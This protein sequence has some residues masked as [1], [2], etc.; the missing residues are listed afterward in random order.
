MNLTMNPNENTY[1][2]EC[3]INLDIH[4]IIDDIWIDII[5]FLNGFDFISINQTCKYF[6]KLT[7]ESPIENSKYHNRIK[8]H[9]AIII[10][11]EYTKIEQMS[12]VIDDELSEA[13]PALEAARKSLQGIK[14]RQLDELR[15]YRNPPR[16]VLMTFE[17]VCILLKKRYRDWDEIRRHIKDSRFMPN[18]I[19]FD[20]TTVTT[21]MRKRLWKNYLSN[22]QFTYERVNHMSKACGPIVQWVKAQVKFAHLLDS[23][24]PMTME[25]EQYKHQFNQNKQKYFPKQ[26]M[27]CL[28]T[29]MYIYYTI[30]CY[31]HKVTIC[32]D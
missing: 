24:E 4:L 3:K 2:Q 19:Q 14:K 27:S 26:I 7:N 13:R 15:W 12:L 23:V 5:F 31:C 28:Y 11:H 29:Y 9:F 18:L 30:L 6:Y 1:Q 22:D 25:L 10:K 32:Y 20:T 17:A 16:E 21:K 8:K